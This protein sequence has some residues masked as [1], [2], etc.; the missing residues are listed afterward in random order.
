MK[1]KKPNKRSDEDKTS[2]NEPNKK[3]KH[4]NYQTQKRKTRKLHLEHTEE[5]G[6]CKDL[7]KNKESQKKT[8]ILELERAKKVTW[9]NEDIVKGEISNID[10]SIAKTRTWINNLESANQHIIKVLEIFNAEETTIYT[11]CREGLH[12]LIT[13]SNP[14][15][16]QQD[17]KR[18]N[19]EQI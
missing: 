3:I 10:N 9:I 14:L 6:R 13:I 1:I 17:V 11:K 5:I 15:S 4:V 16:S 7:I 18:Q 12:A 2:K 8:L 19:S